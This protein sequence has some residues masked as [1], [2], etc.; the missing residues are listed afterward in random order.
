MF[1]VAPRY[2]SG[3][4]L[5]LGDDISKRTSTGELVIAIGPATMGPSVAVQLGSLDSATAIYGTNNPLV[6]ALYE[7]YDGYLDGGQKNPLNYVCLR[8]GGK[9]ATITTS[10]GLGLKTTD[11]YD[12]IE[13]DYFVFVNNTSVDNLAVKVWD[14][15]KL[16]V[17]DSTKGISTGQFDSN[18]TVLPTGDGGPNAIFGT[19]LDRDPLG[20]PVTLAQLVAL[21]V[22]DPAGTALTVTGALTADATVIT[23]AEDVTLFPSAG[24]LQLKQTNGGLPATVV[25]AA[26]SALDTV[27]KTFTLVSELGA[28]LSSITT[29][30]LIGATL[31]PGDSE[32]GLSE[33][34]LYEK[35]RNALQ[36]IEMYTP[37]YIV[38]GG[39]VYNQTRTFDKAY[40]Q[41]TTLKADLTAASTYAIVDAAAQWPVTGIVDLFDG[42]THDLLRYSGNTVSGTDFRLAL[43][44]PSYACVTSGVDFKTVTCTVSGTDPLANL[45][46]S[47]YIKIGTTVSAYTASPSTPGV[48]TLATAVAI[49]DR[50]VL[51]AQKVPGATLIATVPVLASTT[52]TKQENF[53]LGIGFVKE[54][55]EGGFFSFEWSDVKAAGFNVAHFGYLLA[56]FCNE[57][58]VGYNTPLCGMNVSLPASYDR[59]SIVAWAGKAPIFKVQVQN[60]TAVEAVV[61]N[62]TGLLGDPTLQGSVGYNRVYMS[63]PAENAWADPAY[64]LLMTDEGFIDGHEI[65]DSS[66]NVVDLGKFMCVGAGILTFTNKSSNISYYNTDGVYALGMLAGTTKTE[67]I[68]YSKIGTASNANVTVIMNRNISNDLASAGYIVL[69]REKGLGWVLN[70]SNSCVRNQSAYFLISTTRTVKYVV[71]GKRSILVG[72]IGKPVNR[73]IYEAA[74]T[75]LA[76]SF[77]ADV[78]AGFLASNPVWDLTIVESARAIGKF[79]LRCALNPAL[80]LTQVDIDAVIDRGQ[81]IA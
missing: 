60:D 51:V 36:D 5:F 73:F 67:G 3:V 62:G 57:A 74:R 26:Y 69:T 35:F 38:P 9:Q 75:A 8:V 68:S 16:I 52:Y 11:A 27:T 1:K 55:D 71:E 39:I 12:G 59:S 19:D 13:N 30:S 15:N 58:T 14:K 56:N 48:L 81:A 43:E 64:G 70:N 42:V 34:E 31:V 41:S 44:T 65:L 22:I 54:T 61:M 78:K 66:N 79:Q 10:F 2:L 47:G 17:L 80:E 7:F 32:L 40:S 50:T 49:A 46:T 18:F 63:N 21:D 77:S 6:K 4:S 53:E 25:L 45:L 20:T 24:T 76:E 28:A 29:V 33:R 72:F 23:V 37:D